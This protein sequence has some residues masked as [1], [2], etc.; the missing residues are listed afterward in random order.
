[1]FVLASRWRWCLLSLSLWGCDG[2]RK[3]QPV[4]AFER[5]A[6]PTCD[7]Q[8]LPAGEVVA[9]GHLRSGPLMRE[10][11][12]VEYFEIR[13][14]ACITAVTVRQEW[15]RAVADLE[16]LF[17]R[18][19]RPLRVWKRLTL[20]GVQGGM[21]DL[22]LYEAGN[23]PVRMIHRS[24]AGVVQYF[25]L[26]GG[27]PIAV[28]GPGRGLLTLWIQAAKLEVGERE[29]GAVLDVRGL[30][31][32][33]QAALRRDPDRYEASLHRSVRVY[34]IFGRESVFAD[35]N[36]VVIGD[37]SGLRPDASLDTE[38]PPP[39]PRYGLTDPVNTP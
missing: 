8:P 20:P 15:P 21:P 11:D 39:L 1:M 22:H 14:Q 19:L 34:T 32:V 36:D 5:L 35:D 29:R 6:Y 31:Q 23:A 37:L 3:Q 2:C 25:V 9:S 38:A 10:Q 33:T 24:P 28:V 7:G 12:V 4:G 27:R 17:D 13:R 26:P 16:V 30:E 18:Q